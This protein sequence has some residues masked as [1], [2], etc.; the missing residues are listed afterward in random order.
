VRDIR[1]NIKRINALRRHLRA[2]VAPQGSRQAYSALQL[3]FW[4]PPRVLPMCWLLHR[5]SLAAPPTRLLVMQVHQPG[6]M[7]A[8]RHYLPALNWWARPA[9]K[10]RLSCTVLQAGMQIYRLHAVVSNFT[11]L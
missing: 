7:R 9:S 1:P 4:G 6:A 10:Y 8:M 11:Y 2:F 3:C 5:A